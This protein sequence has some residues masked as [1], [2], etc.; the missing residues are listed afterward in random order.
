V[1]DG[2]GDGPLALEVRDEKP[3][4]VPDLSLSSDT[5]LQTAGIASMLIEAAAGVQSGSDAIDVKG[6]PR[7][8]D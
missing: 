1:R 6:G 5:D 3:T 8:R 7:L 2:T 4:V